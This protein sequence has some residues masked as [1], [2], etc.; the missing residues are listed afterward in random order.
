[1]AIIDVDNMIW[2]MENTMEHNFQGTAEERYI[3]AKQ[4]FLDNTS[5]IIEDNKKDLIDNCKGV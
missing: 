1:M 2:E 4:L 3:Q 5:A